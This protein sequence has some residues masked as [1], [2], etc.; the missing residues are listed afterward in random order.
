MTTT[1]GQLGYR[2][3][4]QLLRS[5]QGLRLKTGPFANLIRSPLP[6]V[7]QAIT[8]LYGSY[9]LLQADDFIDFQVGVRRPPGL[10]RWW[11][12]QVSFELDGQA[13]FNPLPGDQGFPLLEWGLNWC[14]YGMCH[15]YLI[16]HAAVLERD[17]KA[18]ILPAPSGSGKSTLCA[19]LLFSGWRLMSD[20]LALLDPHSGHWIANPRPVSLKNDSID[21]ISRRVPGIEFGSRVHETSKGT[22]AHFAAPPSAVHSAGRPALPGW[23][24]LPRWKAGS[25]TQL[26]PLEKARTLMRLVE[27]AFNYDIFGAEGFELLAQAVTHSECFSFEYGDLDEAIACISELSRPATGKLNPAVSERQL[28]S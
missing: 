1:V 28:P 3:V 20:E 6:E 21:V 18:L 4:Q 14:V 25:A 9:P 22:V 27:N 23:I 10:R 7:A 5:R 15:Q 2:E 16:L 26:E 11:Q 13:P 19:G 8:Q 12:P 24:I 17:G